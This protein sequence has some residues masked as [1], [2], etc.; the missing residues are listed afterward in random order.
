MNVGQVDLH[1][2]LLDCGD[3]VAQGYRGVRE[4]IGVDQ[5]HGVELLAGFVQP[6]DQLPFVIAVSGD[7]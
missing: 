2:R 7:K 6:I 5:K 4:S 1:A 3:G